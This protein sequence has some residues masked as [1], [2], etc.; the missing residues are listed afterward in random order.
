MK[1]RRRRSAGARFSPRPRRAV[2]GPVLAAAPGRAAP[3]EGAAGGAVGEGCLGGRGGGPGRPRRLWGGGWRG[4]G[5]GGGRAGGGAGAARGGGLGWWP[6]R[7]FP[8]YRGG[9]WRAPPA[10]PAAGGR[11]AGTRCAG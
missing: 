9:R 2:Q 6:R 4:G 5:W 1:L 7:S 3:R 11:A 10:A 8:L